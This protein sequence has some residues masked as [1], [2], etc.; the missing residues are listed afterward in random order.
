MGWHKQSEKQKQGKASRKQ[1]EKKYILQRAE[2][3]R[4]EN[5]DEAE[6]IGK[7]T[8]NLCLFSRI[9]TSKARETFGEHFPIFWEALSSQDILLSY[10]STCT[11]S[12]ESPKEHPLGCIVYRTKD[13]ELFSEALLAN[14][15]FLRS[16]ENEKGVLPFIQGMIKHYLGY[17]LLLPDLNLEKAIR[18]TGLLDKY[19]IEL[20]VEEA[21]RLPLFSDLDNRDRDFN[22]IAND[23]LYSWESAPVGWPGND[24]EIGD[25]SL[26]GT[27][28]GH[29]TAR[30][31]RQVT[32]ERLTGKD[33]EESIKLEEKCY[34]ALVNIVDWNYYPKLKRYCFWDI[35]MHAAFIYKWCK[36]KS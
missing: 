17:G 15:R 11:F 2:K 22:K 16:K 14:E 12:L 7:L 20:T 19:G 27:E 29:S 5:S 36:S 9:D 23:Y 33:K 24:K 35:P 1:D 34:F 31:L 26:D 10:I 4:V 8:G 3:I 13:A 30:R 28:S 18:N 21:E 32:I 25:F 6:F